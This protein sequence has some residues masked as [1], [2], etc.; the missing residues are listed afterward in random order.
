MLEMPMIG[1]KRINEK[2]MQNIMD[3]GDDGIQKQTSMMYN[4]WKQSIQQREI[5]E[6]FFT[7]FLNMI[8]VFITIFIILVQN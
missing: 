6:M 7:V 4:I 5:D 8:L 3:F 2:L 1:S